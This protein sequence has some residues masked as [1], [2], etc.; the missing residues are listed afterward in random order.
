VE[1]FRRI[2]TPLRIA[3]AAVLL[4]FA[5]LS[6]IIPWWRLRDGAAAARYR[7]WVVVLEDGGTKRDR[8][9]LFLDAKNKPVDREHVVDEY[10]Q[11]SLLGFERGGRIP[12]PLLVVKMPALRP[13][14]D[15]PEFVSHRAAY[16][17]GPDVPKDPWGNP[18]YLVIDYIEDKGTHYRLTPHGD[19]LRV[20]SAGPDG[21]FE[22]GKGD[23]IYVEPLFHS[24]YHMRGGIQRPLDV[25]WEYEPVFVDLAVLVAWCWATW[26]GWRAA[27]SPALGVEALWTT[28]AA[29]LPGAFAYAVA[30]S[31]GLGPLSAEQPWMLVGPHVAAGLTAAGVVWAF[32]FWRRHARELPPA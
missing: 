30:S 21:K 8:F 19:G 6:W 3:G 31:L 10:E 14:R 22:F 9:G 32:V 15:D 29:S 2:V 4:L 24:S 23:D 7:W 25:P 5:S 18:W 27:R 26:R 11:G 13:I 17:S 28:L 12:E 1:R 20:Y 16:A